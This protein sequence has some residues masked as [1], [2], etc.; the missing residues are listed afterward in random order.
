MPARKFTLEDIVEC[1]N[2]NGGN[3]RN[4]AKELG[5]SERTVHRNLSRAKEKGWKL[6]KQRKITF[7]EGRENHGGHMF[8]SL[9]ELTKIGVSLD[10]PYVNVTA[11]NKQIVIK[12]G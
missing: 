9:S 10:Q 1:Y 11:T 7:N 2:R 4:T 12:K 6:T 5:V 8:L 3:A